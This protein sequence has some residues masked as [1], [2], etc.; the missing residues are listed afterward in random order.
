MKEIIFSYLF[1]YL[2]II[3][4]GW[5]YVVLDFGNI[6]MFVNNYAIYFIIFISIV[7]S[8]FLYKKN[9]RKEKN[10]SINDVFFLVCL[11]VSVALI[12]NMTIFYFKPVNNYYFSFPLLISSGIVGPIY[13]EILFRYILYNKLKCKYSKIIAIIID[14]FIFSI[15]HFSIIKCIYAIIL[16]VIFILVY[17]RYQSIKAP[18]IT[19]IAA[20]SIVLFINEFNYFILFLS[21]ITLAIYLYLI[22]RQT[23]T[24]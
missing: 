18:I 7:I 22:F 5:L 13:E 23:K 9:Y 1:T 2:F 6:D 19:H 4:I 20:N 15:I 16:G 12:L 8:F 17:E 24:S 11:G 21:F 10:I 14:V 3:I